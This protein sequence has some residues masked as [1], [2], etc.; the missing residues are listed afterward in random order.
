LSAGGSADPQLRKSGLVPGT[1]EN[2]GVVPE[3]NDLPL[4]ADDDEARRVHNTAGLYF[5]NKSRLTAHDGLSCHE[6]GG[7][8]RLVN[9]P[10]WRIATSNEVRALGRSWCTTCCAV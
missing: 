5:L 6:V 4:V 3:F 7:Y 2:W 9:N 10:A 1:V 8:D